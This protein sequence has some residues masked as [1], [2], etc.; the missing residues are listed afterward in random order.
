MKFLKL[1][2]LLLVAGMLSG[3]ASGEDKAIK[4]KEQ[5]DV[6]KCHLYCSDM[7]ASKYPE[8]SERQFKTKCIRYCGCACDHD[9]FQYCAENI[10]G[11]HGCPAYC[12]KKDF[13]IEECD[14]NA[15]CCLTECETFGE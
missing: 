10:D 12:V 1:S 5:E 15:D 14:G 6:V 8:E 2:S 11:E 7:C 9:S 13:L 4:I 3:C